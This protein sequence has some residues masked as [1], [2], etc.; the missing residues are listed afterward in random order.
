MK[1]LV[2]I[3]FTEV[4]ENALRY[5]I[6]LGDTL[7]VRHIILFHVVSSEKDAPVAQANLNKLID[8]YKAQSHAALESSILPGNIFDKIGKAAV[9]QDAALII[10]GTHGIKGM[11]HIIGS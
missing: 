9:D 3:D 10:M 5:A 2:P 1:I 11:Q 4:T 8:K 7:P 6:G